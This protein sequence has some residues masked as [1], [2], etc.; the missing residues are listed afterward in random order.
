MGTIFVWVVGLACFVVMFAHYGPWDEGEYFFV[1]LI[2]ALPAGLLNLIVVRVVH[3]TE[4]Q[5][6]LW[7][8]L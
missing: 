3:D 6:L 1:C 7:S 8:I 5:Q 2:A 4:W